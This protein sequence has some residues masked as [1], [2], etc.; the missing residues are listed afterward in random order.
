[1]KGNP[2][3]RLSVLFIQRFWHGRIGRYY[4]SR[5]DVECRFRPTCSEYCVEAVKKHGFVK[6]WLKTFR[7][8][9]R[10]RESYSGPKVDHP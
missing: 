8:I 3:V 2:L 6:G 10:C 1:M 7:R 5:M 4:R 9:S